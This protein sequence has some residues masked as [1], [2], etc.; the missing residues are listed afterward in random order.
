MVQQVIV[1][2]TFDL[3]RSFS[4]YGLIEWPSIRWWW[5]DRLLLYERR[6]YFAAKVKILQ[7]S[8]KF[9]VILRHEDVVKEQHD[10]TTWKDKSLSV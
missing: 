3:S 10:S 5:M 1:T 2:L 9:V 7:N 6:D 8:L 4:G